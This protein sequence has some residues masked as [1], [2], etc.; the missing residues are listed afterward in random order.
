MPGF[1]RFGHEGGYFT[2]TWRARSDFE[3]M[4]TLA[5]LIALGYEYQ[6]IVSHDMCR[7][8]FLSRFGGY[9]YDHVLVRI[10]PRLQKTFGLS[11]GGIAKLLVDNPRRLLTVDQPVAA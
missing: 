9:G 11:D 2:P 1:G 8:H 6:L 3:K 5:E 10:T 4:T 7:K